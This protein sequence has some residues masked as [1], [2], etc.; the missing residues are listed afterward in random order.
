MNKHIYDFKMSHP[1]E[2]NHAMNSKRHKYFRVHFH[3]H[4]HTMNSN[5]KENVL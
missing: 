5:K 1:D 2:L 3:G 4:T